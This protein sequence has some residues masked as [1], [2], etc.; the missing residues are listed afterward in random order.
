MR[1]FAAVLIAMAAT[2]IAAA[3]P[4]PP[5]RVARLNYISGTVSFQPGGVSDWAPAVINRPLTTGDQLWV[6]E[7]GRAEMHLGT[8]ALRLDQRT[9]IEFLNLDDQN[10]Q[11]RL[12]EGSLIVRLRR[13]DEN[14]TFEVDTPNLAF[15]LLRPGTYRIYANPDS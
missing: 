9:A 15:S 5:G 13:L 10:V 12:P 8:A 7:S 11:I 4:D 6:D 14:Q 3:E 2:S 1:L